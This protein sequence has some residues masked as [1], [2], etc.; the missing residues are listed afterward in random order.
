MTA[1]AATRHLLFMPPN[2]LGDA[3]MA[4]PAMRALATHYQPDKLTLCGRSWLADLLPYLDLPDAEYNPAIPQADLAFLFPN[5]FRSAWQAYRSGT[6]ERIGFR[7]QWRRLLLT[8]PLPRRL[9]LRHEHHRLY[10][11]DI[12][13]QLDIPV[14][15]QEVRLVAPAG[16]REA[17]AQLMQ[18]HGL[19]PKRTICVAP[20]AQFG[21]A[22]RYPPEYYAHILGWL[23][24]AGWQPVVLGVAAERAIGEQVL[25]KVQGPQW[26]AAGETRLRE[27]LQMVAACRLMLCNDS[28]FMHVAA[29]L[30]IPTVTM[31]GATD[32]ARTSPSGPRVKLF[33]EPAD[34]SPCLQ[35]E[36]SV[37]GQPCMANI[38][39]EMVR[40]ACLAMLA[41]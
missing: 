23:A 29:G 14:T 34:C 37:A 41:A 15:E 19:D 24:A 39:P 20:G 16:D 1:P 30:G 33:Y 17:G 18:Q 4:Q 35:R 6:A 10:Y 11:L 7:G 21:G 40:D 13:A 27:A 26:N 32:P 3:V 12:A 28:G 8:Q 25:E 36:C 31:F 5:S 9:S 38:L 22:K 2:W